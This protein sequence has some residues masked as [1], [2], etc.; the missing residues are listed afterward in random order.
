[1]R[2]RPALAD[3]LLALVSLT[4]SAAGA[5][6]YL[7]HYRPVRGVLYRLHPRYLHTL[8]PGAR[9]LFVHQPEDGGASLLV[10]V[11]S[12]GFLGPELLHSREGA[13]RVLVYGDSFAAGEFSPLEDRFANQLARRLSDPDG[14]R[15]EA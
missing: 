15:V 10:R 9:R 14:P 3:L 11:N 13:R 1:M 8:I 2:R 7:R 5:E 6:L 4:L 12:E